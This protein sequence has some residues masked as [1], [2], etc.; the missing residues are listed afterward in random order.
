[1]A[2]PKMNKAKLFLILLF[3]FGTQAQK[4]PVD[5]IKDVQV[6]DSLIIHLSS[7]L[8][9]DYEYYLTNSQYV[10]YED[11]NTRRVLNADVPSFHILENASRPGFA[12]DKS[13]IYFRG[14]LLEID[15]NGFEILSQYQTTEK[16]S[17]LLWKTNDAVYKN[18]QALPVSDVA[19]F[20]RVEDG[21]DSYLK[22]TNYVYYYDK[23]IEYSD[24]NTIR[25]IDYQYAY[26][27]DNVYDKGDVVMYDG[28]KLIAVNNYL[29]KNSKKVYQ[30]INSSFQQLPEVDP[31]SLHYISP[32][33]SADRNHVYYQNEKL[34]ILPENFSQ[35]QTWEQYNSRFISDGKNIYYKNKKEPDLDAASFGML[36]HSDFF[37]DKN[38]VYRRRYLWEKDTVVNQRFPFRYKEDVTA[39]NVRITDVSRYVLYLN[40][41]YDPW[42]NNLYKRLTPQQTQ[43]AMEGKLIDIHSELTKID[44]RYSRFLYRANSAIYWQDKILDVDVVSFEKVGANVYRDAQHTYLVLSETGPMAY[45]E[46]DPKTLEVKNGLILDKNYVYLRDYRIIENRELEFLGIFPGYR[47]VCSQDRTPGSDFYLM[48]NS[49]GYWLVSVSSEPSLRF[50]GTSLGDQSDWYPGLE[51]ELKI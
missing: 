42:S 1:M 14:Q 37:F 43:W 30:L 38:G 27:Q 17:I 31:H 19:S 15:T 32:S 36:P 23:K 48:K 10:I 29:F 34:S 21:Y 25:C 20:A 18:E 12:A 9:Y 16:E 6:N 7:C 45:D 2:L 3:P 28:E 33:Y 13:G 24:P 8:Y 22:D 11:C 5:K 26:D 49:K 50:L 39:K 41:A 35:L 44:E 51:A 40:Q 46:I 47:R 4:T